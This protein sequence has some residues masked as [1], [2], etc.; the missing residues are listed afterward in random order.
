M[1]LIKTDEIRRAA[2]SMTE[3]MRIMGQSNDATSVHAV[4]QFSGQKNA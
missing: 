2:E 4:R 1:A 3:Q